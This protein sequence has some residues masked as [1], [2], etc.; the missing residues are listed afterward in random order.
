MCTRDNFDPALCQNSQ[1]G[2]RWTPTAVEKKKS[3]LE[4]DE[5][6][7]VFDAASI[8]VDQLLFLSSKSKA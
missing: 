7:S 2:E 4:T 8:S 3:N 6:I 5:T 1:L